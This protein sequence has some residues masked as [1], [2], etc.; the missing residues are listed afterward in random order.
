LPVSIVPC[1][2]PPSGTVSPLRSDSASKPIA[3]RSAASGGKPTKMPCVS[4]M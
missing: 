1:A 4:V 3:T 2:W